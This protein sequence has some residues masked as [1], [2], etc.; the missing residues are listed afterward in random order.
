MS[1]EVRCGGSK[2]IMWLVVPQVI[3]WGEVPKYQAGPCPGC[4]DCTIPASAESPKPEL[5]APADQVLGSWKSI[6]SAEPPS[7]DKSGEL[8]L[9]EG[10]EQAVAKRLQETGKGES[11]TSKEIM[12]IGLGRSSDGGRT[13][14]DIGANSELFWLR[15]IAL[16]LAIANEREENRPV[17]SINTSM[18]ASDLNRI[19]ND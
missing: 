17:Q 7:P 2:K 5:F 9:P 14:V 4:P 10:F 3:N 19:K 6:N 15:E 12:S 1:N 18:L 8:E 11:M 16:Q 13:F